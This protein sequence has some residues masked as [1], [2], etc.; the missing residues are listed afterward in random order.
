[1]TTDPQ[2]AAL[3]SF[4]VFLSDGYLALLPPHACDVE[5]SK[6]RRFFNIADKL[7]MDLQA[8]LCYRA[9]QSGKSILP[10]NEIESSFIKLAHLLMGK[11]FPAHSRTLRISNRA[12][13][14]YVAV[15]LSAILYQC[16]D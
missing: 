6:T 13:F 7:P 11:E 15:F 10:M 14:I 4:V 2:A 9:C 8:V 16:L 3:F 1:M 5:S 12:Y